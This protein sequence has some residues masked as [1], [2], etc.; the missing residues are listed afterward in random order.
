MIELVSRKTMGGMRDGVESLWD[1]GGRIIGRLGVRNPLARRSWTDSLAARPGLRAFIS[2]LS[3]LTVAGIWM[4]LRKKRQV[5]KH[6]TMGEDDAVAWEGGS[7]RSY[8]ASE[9]ALT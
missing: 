2:V 4:Y 6:Y 5:T 9:S 8:K 3:A 1:G 7:V